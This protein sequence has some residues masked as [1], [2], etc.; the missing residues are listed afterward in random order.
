MMGTQNT[1]EAAAYAAEWAA[2]T[3]NQ[4]RFQP[5]EI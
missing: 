4:I 1:Y 2:R 3:L 5:M